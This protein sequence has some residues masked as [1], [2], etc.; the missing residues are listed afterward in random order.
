MS[1]S[2]QQS[3]Y[4]SP[5]PTLNLPCYQ[6]TVWLGEGWV[7]SNNDIDLNLNVQGDVTK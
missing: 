3:T 6:L 2:E 4:S 5:N 1:V 7:H